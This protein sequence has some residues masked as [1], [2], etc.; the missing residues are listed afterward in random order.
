MTPTRSNSFLQTARPL[1]IALA[2]ATLG[3]FVAAAQRRA[4][5]A[6]PAVVPPPAVTPNAASE[7]AVPPHVV[8]PSAGSQRVVP[9]HP[10]TFL[11][12]SKI[13]PVQAPLFLR[14]LEPVESSIPDAPR[15]S[16]A[17]PA[18]PQQR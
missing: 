11:P 9:I 13:G 7:Q 1:A 17:P 10:P 16:P 18:R 3:Y 4:N 15:E 6:L 14:G 8:T 5:T 2:L 12:S